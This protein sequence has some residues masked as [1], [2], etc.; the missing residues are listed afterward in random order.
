MTNRTANM[1]HIRSNAPSLANVPPP[2]LPP[3]GDIPPLGNVK[4]YLAQG[5]SSRDELVPPVPPL[6]TSFVDTTS[7]YHHPS[8][9]ARRSPLVQHLYPPSETGQSSHSNFTHAGPLTQLAIHMALGLLSQEPP[10]LV[11]SQESNITFVGE[12][13]QEALDAFFGL[14]QSQSSSA[15]YWVSQQLQL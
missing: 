1:E 13:T 4:K 15:Q 11:G 3:K 2:L 10:Q 9:V 8:P 12:L 5:Y 6:S 7:L 14:P